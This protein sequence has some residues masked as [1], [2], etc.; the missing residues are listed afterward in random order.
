[1]LVP[2]EPFWHAII[3]SLFVIEIAIPGLKSETWDTRI[4]DL[5]QTWATRRL[6]K[7]RLAKKQT[8]VGMTNSHFF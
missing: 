6:A 3:V 2:D 7:K 4:G 1:M 5:F 8:Q